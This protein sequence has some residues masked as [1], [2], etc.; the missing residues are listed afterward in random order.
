MKYIKFDKRVLFELLPTVVIKE[1]T[2]R[3]FKYKDDIT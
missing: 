3:E 1:F 2:K